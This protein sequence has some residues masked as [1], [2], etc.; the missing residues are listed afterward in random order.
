MFFA[1]YMYAMNLD[2]FCQF[3][4]LSSVC[5][6]LKCNGAESLKYL[7]CKSYVVYYLVW[8][9]IVFINA[10]IDGHAPYQLTYICAIWPEIIYLCG[11]G[12][13]IVLFCGY[14]ILHLIP[15]N[16]SWF[17]INGH[18]SLLRVFFIQT[19]SCELCTL[20]FFHWTSISSTL[21][22]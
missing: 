1:S 19:S 12:M 16:L 7:A 8:K 17:Q 20:C 6:A 14:S 22:L 21:V 9:K 5:R 11:N 2:R 13:N 3:A 10:D 15:T 18:S 4:E